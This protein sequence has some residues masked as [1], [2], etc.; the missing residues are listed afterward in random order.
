MKLY[1]LIYSH[2]T[3]QEGGGRKTHIGKEDGLALCGKNK[4]LFFSFGDEINE[5][6]INQPDPDGELCKVCKKKSLKLIGK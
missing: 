5:W 6:W 4:H 3:V 2:N 1:P